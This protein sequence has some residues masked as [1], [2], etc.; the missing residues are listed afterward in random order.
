MSINNLEHSVTGEC[1][2][3]VICYDCFAELSRSENASTETVTESHK[4]VNGI[5]EQCGHKN[6]CNHEN[7]AEVMEWAEENNLVYEPL[8]NTFHEVTGESSAYT[9]CYDCGEVLSPVENL[10]TITLSEPHYY[11]DGICQQCGYKNTCSHENTVETWYWANW[12]SFTY[13]PFNEK[14]HNITGECY[15]CIQCRDCG[16]ELSR[17]EKTSLKTVQ[18]NHYFIDGICRDC[19]YSKTCSHEKTEDIPGKSATCTES[20][21]TAGKKCSVCGKV[22]VEIGRAH[23]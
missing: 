1:L 10:G 17:S 19:G 7:S 9:V 23:V 14:T 21:L 12:N 20:G 4:Y 11:L 5:C 15:T 22:L 18:Y 8:N 2:R 13:E 3:A 16:M 6:T